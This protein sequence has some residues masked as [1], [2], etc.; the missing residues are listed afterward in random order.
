M[1]YQI[2]LNKILVQVWIVSLQIANLQISQFLHKSNKKGL[3]WEALDFFKWKPCYGTK[4]E[5][6]FL[7]QYLFWV[8][9]KSQQSGFQIFTFSECKNDLTGLF[10]SQPVAVLF[11]FTYANFKIQVNLHFFFN[12]PSKCH[13]QKLK[14]H[15]NKNLA[16]SEMS[17]KLNC[18]KNLTVHQSWNITKT[19]ILK[20]AVWNN[21]LLLLKKTI[22]GTDTHI[23]IK[24][25][26]CFYP[27][28]LHF[29]IYDKIRQQ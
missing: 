7:Y 15:K 1:T 13:R 26:I 28:K 14:C 29:L 25:Y 12:F 5:V 3:N 2:T 18:H 4:F 19:K 17:Q 27:Q 6:F 24:K 16:Q 21:Y 11:S 22:Y 20:F 8:I 23:I 9:L 10:T